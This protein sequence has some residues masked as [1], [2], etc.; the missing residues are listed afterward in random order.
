MVKNSKDSERKKP[1]ILVLAIDI[2]DDIGRVG[3]KTPIIG[4]ENVKKAAMDFALAR[5]ED[6][7][8]NV[9]FSALNI[10]RQL[11][12]KGQECEVAIIAG[13]A[14][15]YVMA[16][17]KVRE[18]LE[19]LNNEYNIK[20]FVIVSD[21]TED[22]QVIPLVQGFA[23][24]IS[25]KR[26]VVE[27]WRGVEETFIL[28]GRYFKKAVEEPRFARIF[29]GVPG[30]VIFSI[31]LLALLGLLH[32]ALAVAFTI[33]GAYMFLRG[34]ELDTKIVNWWKQSPITSTALILSFIAIG[35]GAT[36][37]YYTVLAAITLTREVSMIALA[38]IIINGM[39]PYVGFS[40]IA[41]MSA[42]IVTKAPS[43]GLK[44]W[45][46]VSALIISA[47][48]IAA[49]YELS[50]RLATLP[51]SATSMDVVRTIMESQILLWL[52][53][54]IIISIVVTVIIS[55]VEE[56]VHPKKSTSPIYQIFFPSFDRI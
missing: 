5:P 52:F 51:P 21:S 19:K 20:G 38:G 56:K 39:L 37:T 8:V 17:I 28:I 34:F 49:L 55:I 2:D 14:Y 46:D 16:G 3:I 10:A 24:I 30:L 15:D 26:V 48:I 18:Q 12:A 31:S 27:Q 43:S 47:L 45:H 35:V 29:L 22:E 6:P 41:L 32:Y 33:I 1:I 44:I 54:I 50:S 4:F 53:V 36:T 25:V 40:V 23:P 11:K 13:D 7:D 9:L 42:R